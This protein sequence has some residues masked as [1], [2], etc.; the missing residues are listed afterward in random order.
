MIIPRIG[1]EWEFYPT[2][3]KRHTTKKKIKNIYWKASAK[4]GGMI[5]FIEWSHTP[6]ARYL[7]DVRVKYFLKMKAKRLISRAKVFAQPFDN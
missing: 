4:T 1:D 7:P 5:P 2:V 3:G 6:S